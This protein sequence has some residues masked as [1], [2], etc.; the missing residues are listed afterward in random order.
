M[1]P[2]AIAYVTI[3]FAV[4]IRVSPKDLL[5]SLALFVASRFARCRA[6]L[7]SLSQF[8][9]KFFDE[10]YP[11]F[12]NVILKVISPLPK[13]IVREKTL[14]T[15]D[16]IKK[17]L[18]HLEEKDIQQACW[19]ALAF[20]SGAR[21]SELFRFTINNIDVNKTAFDGIFLET[22][23]AEAGGTVQFVCCSVQSE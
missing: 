12:R 21:F 6:T 7:S 11:S 23:R 16:D 10:E 4:C 14:L 9:E 17:L 22:V 8:I 18:N 20:S 15:E 13:N 3:L 2:V 5:C 1:P 19:L